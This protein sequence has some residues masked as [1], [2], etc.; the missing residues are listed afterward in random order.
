ML[1]RIAL[2]ALLAAAAIAAPFGAQAELF[3]W[4]DAEGVVNYGDQLPAGAKDAKTL[5]E[6]AAM[7][8]VVPGLPRE[9]IERERERANEA[10]IEELERELQE[11]RTREAA[12]TTLP[13]SNSY[14]PSSLV[15][16]PVGVPLYAYPI[17]RAHPW[18]PHVPPVHGAPVKRT[19]PAKGMVLDWPLR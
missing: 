1:V 6:A 8:S 4:I 3:R 18:P 2:P 13:A 11:L 10:R 15:A 9:V 12:R 19:P 7:V 14:E 17:R 5:D 16:Y